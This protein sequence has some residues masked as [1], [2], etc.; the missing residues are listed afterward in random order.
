MML[1]D[2]P[3]PG[4]CGPLGVRL[5][6]LLAMGKS[7][8]HLFG[9]SPGVHLGDISGGIP[10]TFVGE[11]HDLSYVKFMEKYGQMKH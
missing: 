7:S 1:R 8:P 9:A 11:K 4:S 10:L 2:L 6:A 5:P 3:R